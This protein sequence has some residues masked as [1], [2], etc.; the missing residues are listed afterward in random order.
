VRGPLRLRAL[1]W[2]CLGL[3]PIVWLGTY[4][5]EMLI[6]AESR[7]PIRVNAAARMSAAW[8]C[9]ILELESRFKF[10]RRTTGKHV[11]LI[12][13]GSTPYAERLVREMDQH[14]LSMAKVLNQPM[15]TTEQA[16]VRG[17]LVGQ[18]GRAIL[19]WGM[20]AL[21]E[22]VAEL[23]GLDK[24]EM[25]HTLITMMGDADQDPPFLLVEGWAESQSADRAV[26]ITHLA[27]MYEAKRTYSLEELVAPIWYG[28]GQGPVYWEG[29]PFA[30][31]LLD[32]FGGEKFF[33][34]YAGVRHDSF[35]ADS[36][37][38]LGVSWKK[39]EQDFWV[40]V[41]EESKAIQAEFDNKNKEGLVKKART[42]PTQLAYAA[43]VNQADWVELAT[44]Y[45]AA[46]TK[47]KDVPQDVALLI[48]LNRIVTDTKA[49]LNDEPYH[50]EFR[51]D[52]GVEQFWVTEDFTRNAKQVLQVKGDQCAAL[53]RDEAGRYQG[54]ASGL[55]NAIDVRSEMINAYQLFSVMDDANMW[56]RP[57]EMWWSGIQMT[58]VSL[59]RPD[60]EGEDTWKAVFEWEEA[61]YP[62][63]HRYQ[64]EVQPSLDWAVISWTRERPG[65]VL[66]GGTCEY[67]RINGKV[68]PLSVDAQYSN[69]D[70]EVSTRM[71]CRELNEDER[72]VLHRHVEAI[73]QI[74]PARPY[75]TLRRILSASVLAVP[76][77]GL[78]CLA[79]S[80]RILRYPVAQ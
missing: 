12:D 16:W 61:S 1:G 52:F 79:I 22:P 2:L 26:Q 25:A 33:E 23:T 9:S 54:R 45:Q 59:N 78:V 11:V 67:Q 30:H 46:R 66:Y 20:C 56:L 50:F 75:H 29:G 60:G 74:G 7:E 14:L 15:P 10:S 53:W 36:E 68:L 80:Q 65:A 44:K 47:R 49:G 58:L 69:E 13:D 57:P 43:D 18:T 21:N 40:W 39:M 42:S 27:D 48:E 38:I 5:T 37:R 51:S 63:T 72:Q 71:K 31:Y 34:L 62:G 4:F 24:H 76:L 6:R 64:I 35:H 28:T 17:S 8:S 70:G 19:A 32:R 73:V 55:Q 41:E 77:L 3:T